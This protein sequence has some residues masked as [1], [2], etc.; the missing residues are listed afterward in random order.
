MLLML[1]GCVIW[2]AGMELGLWLVMTP[3]SRRVPL[4][5]EFVFEFLEHDVDVAVREFGKTGRCPRE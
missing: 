3:R 4:V 5:F 1:W 2:I